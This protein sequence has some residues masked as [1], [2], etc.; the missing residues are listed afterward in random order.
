MKVSQFLLALSILGG[1]LTA[2]KSSENSPP[3]P[4]GSGIDLMISDLEN[5]YF[6]FDSRTL[7]RIDLNMDGEDDFEFS[8]RQAGNR[9]G[10]IL[11]GLSPNNTVT[12]QPYL[13]AGASIDS[14]TV[15]VPE[16]D[17]N[18]MDSNLDNDY[19]TL[20]HKYLGLRM[21]IK[22]ETHYG[23]IRF[24]TTDSTIGAPLYYSRLS[25]TLHDHGFN[26]LCGG[27]TTP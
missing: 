1:L 22:G 10:R 6:D 23:W 21:E 14:S 19:G 20:D 7:V 26:R 11:S 25:L 24:S 15:F 27:I 12:D 16:F 8:P 17:L 13:D 9:I 18:K 5:H 4:C 2:C 3:G